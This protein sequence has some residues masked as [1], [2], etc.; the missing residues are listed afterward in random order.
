MQS[1][2]IFIVVGIFMIYLY[3]KGLMGLTTKRAVVFVGSL[4][5][6]NSWTAKFSECSGKLRRVIRYDQ[7][8]QYT[9]T[10]E[11]SLDKGELFIEIFDANKNL[12]LTL[13]QDNPSGIIDV[14]SM[15]KGY[16]NVRIKAATGNY[17]VSW[18]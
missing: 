17:Y 7:N 3:E 11:S 12:L 13:D 15:R 10:L 5:K 4:P 1:L 8:K 6:K 14:T 18:E 16:M 9:F 2:Y